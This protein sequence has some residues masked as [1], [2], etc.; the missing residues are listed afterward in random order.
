MPRRSACAVVVVLLSAGFAADQASDLPAAGIFLREAREAVA[1]SQELWHQYA[2]KERST[3][4]HL[5]PFG[6]MGTGAVRVFEV[7]P[8]PNPKLTYRRVIERNGIPLSDEELGRQNAEYQSRVSRFA[9]RDSDPAADLVERRRGEDRL[10]RKRAQMIVE[11]VVENLEF[12]IAR[13]EY[14]AGRPI[15]VVAFAARKDARAVTREGRLARVFRGHLWIDEASREITELR[16][17]ATDDVA[18]GGFVAKVYE[19]TKAVIVRQEIEPGVWMPT[20]LTLSGGVRALFRRA[21]I[22]HVVEWFDY[23]RIE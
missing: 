5:N 12:E 1:R 7:R 20:R 8:S 23:R 3:E 6:R 16:A 2:Y 9:P 13:R 15:I 22:D 14:R 19:G 21:R 11:D 17:V 10:A 4:L 18:F